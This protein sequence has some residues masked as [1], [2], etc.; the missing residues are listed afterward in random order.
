M[1]PVPD[2]SEP[3]SSPASAEK[4]GRLAQWGG[5]LQAMQSVLVRLL[6]DLVRREGRMGAQRAAELVQVNEQLVLAA[7]GSQAEAEV[8]V[9]ALADVD[10]RGSLDPLTHLP[11]RT[12]LIDHFAQEAA[13]TARHGGHFA[14][15]F[16][17]L[18]NFKSIND[19]YGHP[20]GDQVLQHVTERMVAL[21]RAVDTVSRHGG[22]EFIVLLAEL[23][24]PADALA[25][26]EKLIA[27]IDTPFELAGRTVGMTASIGIALYPDHGDQ[28]ETLIGLA[29]AAMY[30]SKRR[31]P[32]GIAFHGASPPRLAGG[33]PAPTP[34]APRRPRRRA[35]EVA[36]LERQL[37]D[38][39]EA[40]ENLLLATL[41]AQELQAAAEQALQR[42]SEFLAAVGGE[43]RNPTSPI[44]IA[45]AMLGRDGADEALLPLV[46]DL[47]EKKVSRV[48]RLID[49]LSGVAL[50]EA[51]RFEVEPRRVDLAEVID[52]AVE[53]YRP[54]MQ[55]RDQHFETQRPP[56]PLWTHGDAARLG[57]VV[58]NLLDNASKHTPDGGRISLW[59][60]QG[61]EGLTLRV[62]DSGIG[63]TPE[64]LPHVFE[65]FVQDA[66][67]FGINGVGLG[68]G[69]TVVRALVQAHGGQI[70]ARSAGPDQGSQFVVTLPS[71]DAPAGVPAEPT[72]GSPWISPLTH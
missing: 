4:Q 47:T 70:E 30:Q 52:Q 67:A 10:R 71:A 49:G 29:D 59:V 42:Q 37:A 24:N 62:E 45:S 72:P 60:A 20:F 41:G 68:I 18:D 57:Q 55:R 58:R 26:A 61:P 44:R 69:L 32:G 33:P 13:R 38:L 15:L 7:L 27:A 64:A 31:G 35:D 21:A 56:G 28:L 43:L 39:R 12:T 14:L 22:D 6:Q 9:K 25:A 17:D 1:K 40:N 50:G 46:Q 53:A 16:I 8:H 2:P 36:S 3:P 19:A 48:V 11:T 51:E 5:H 65:P 54:T 34:E 66:Q 63:I 23:A